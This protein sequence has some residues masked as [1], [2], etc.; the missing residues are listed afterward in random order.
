VSD[1][2]T[3]RTWAVCAMLT[4]AAALHLWLVISIARQPLDVQ[5][6]S[7]DRSAVWGLFNDTMF[8]VG[9]GADFFAVYRAG[10]QSNAGSPYHERWGVGNDPPY[11]YPY[12][13]LPVVAHT[14]GRWSNQ[15]TPRAAY[16]TWLCV[17]ELT[18]AGF[19]GLF[20]WWAR[21]SPETRIAGTFLLLISTPFLLELHMGQ[22]TFLS[23]VLTC[24]ALVLLEEWRGR[25]GAISAL[26]L[27]TVAA[28]LKVYPLVVA[29]ALIRHRHSR[30]VAVGAAL[31]L[32]VPAAWY[33]NAH[34]SDW[35]TFR[36]VN[37][38]EL[39]T[40]YQTGNFGL[41]YAAWVV[42]KELGYEWSENLYRVVMRLWQVGL[43]GATAMLVLLSPR[44]LVV[45]GATLL[46]AYFLTYHHVW[47]HHYS[48]AM[49]LGLLV[50][51][52]SIRCDASDRSGGLDSNQIAVAI[53]WIA[54]VLIALPTPFALWHAD[55]PSWQSWP[56]HRR[57]LLSLS[58]SLPLL[59]IFVLGVV[60]LLADVRPRRGA[61]DRN[62]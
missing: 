37:L 1:R 34:P 54:L 24:S 35:T 61:G 47:E 33:F 49:P 45:G 4:L 25:G 42:P 22:F 28:L 55:D 53:G 31:A 23:C 36:D 8:R 29:P 19:I 41:V 12:R 15:S 27:L 10:L 39:S 44:R 14:L 18:L 50:L 30:S 46:C 2:R 7:P 59:A 48:A 60:Q 16:L 11:A 6:E 5:R 38:A 43:L 26:P 3:W 62:A 21:G 56:G 17:L 20:W 52:G 9:P 57:G 51:A 40:D 58:K 32:F 13:Y